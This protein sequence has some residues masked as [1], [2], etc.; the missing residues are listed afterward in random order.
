MR[1]LLFLGL[2][3]LLAAGGLST[4]S[5][6]LAQET[7]T[8][9]LT[10]TATSTP[11]EPPT[12]IPTS[13]LTQTPEQTPDETPEETPEQTP[14][15]VIPTETATSTFPPTVIPTL[16]ATATATGSATAT[17]TPIATTP[18]PAG[19]VTRMFFFQGI[20]NT[21]LDLY[22][23]GFLI[24]GNIATGSIAGPFNILDGTAA[25]LSVFTTG[26]TTQPLLFSTLA[27]DPGSIVLVVVYLGPGDVPTLT[28][29][30]LKFMNTSA[31]SVVFVNASTEA[32][33][34]ISGAL[35]LSG[36]AG[37]IGSGQAA[38]FEVP[39]EVAS[40]LA[41]P[42][43]IQAL[44]PGQVYVVIATGSQAEGTFQVTIRALDAGLNRAA[45]SP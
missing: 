25:N 8:A 33:L 10:E 30:P 7:P 43:G 18:A 4:G 41:P 16:T 1:K 26:N 14:T 44:Q 9:T 40:R 13:T 20:P 15:V 12:A 36:E 45:V 2:V 22:G 39:P 11:T 34:D 17:L 6:V 38:Q 35:G 28:V 31:N 37:V 32:A 21:S 42:S 5:V 23:N 27:F 29:F 19:S 3:L 24:G